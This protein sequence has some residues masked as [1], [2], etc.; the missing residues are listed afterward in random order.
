MIPLAVIVIKTGMF[1]V[2]KI[3][4]LIAFPF[5]KDLLFLLKRKI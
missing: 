4:D 5:L 2:S 1:D 3:E